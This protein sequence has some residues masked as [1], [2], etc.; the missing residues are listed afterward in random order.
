[1]LCTFCNTKHSADWTIER[2]ISRAMMTTKTSEE[3]G[4]GRV[5]RRGRE[6]A[7]ERVT[8]LDNT[9]DSGTTLQSSFRSISVD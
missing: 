2:G 6:T 9:T 7:A 5:E 3:Q 4:S 8:V 1:M